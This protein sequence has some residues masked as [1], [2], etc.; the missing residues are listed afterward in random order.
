MRAPADTL[1]DTIS[2][3]S[4]NFS[5]D[6]VWKKTKATGVRKAPTN[7][8]PEVS[9]VNGMLTFSNMNSAG[10]VRLFN[11]QGALMMIQSFQPGARISMRVEKKLSK[12]NYTLSITQKNAVIQKQIVVQ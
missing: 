12:G 5:V 8:N 4:A 3:D 6:L 9:F 1:I 10:S 11:A 7:T 2:L